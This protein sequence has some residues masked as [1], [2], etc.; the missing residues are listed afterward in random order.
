MGCAHPTPRPQPPSC[1]LGWG[2]RFTEQRPPSTIYQILCRHVGQHSRA[3]LPPTHKLLPKLGA[4]QP[5]RYAGL[6]APCSPGPVLPA[7]VSSCTIPASLLV[8]Q[9]G[10]LHSALWVLH[11][12]TAQLKRYSSR[13][14]STMAHQHESLLQKSW[15]L[16][17]LGSQQGPAFQPCS[18]LLRQR[19]LAQRQPFASRE[20]QAAPY[21][22]RAPG[23]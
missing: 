1:S 4:W 5:P 16:F 17:M 9:P 13:K 18:W 22:Q 15:A 23:A 6:W 21:L 14:S 19:L 8:V 10:V 20:I 12:H 11:T 3:S 7:S 2:D